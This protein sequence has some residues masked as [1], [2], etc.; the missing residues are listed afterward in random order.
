[1]EILSHVHTLKE[2]F[3]IYD[4]RIETFLGIAASSVQLASKENGNNFILC[5]PKD[6]S[7]L[8]GKDLVVLDWAMDKSGFCFYRKPEKGSMT[9]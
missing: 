7:K 2:A 3:F 9:E 4:S 5:L 1:M 8:E 6:I